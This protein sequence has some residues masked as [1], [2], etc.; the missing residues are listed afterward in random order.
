M[1]GCRAVLFLVS[2]ILSVGYAAVCPAS[3]GIIPVAKFQTSALHGGIPEGWSLEKKTG[4]PVIS[5]EKDNDAFYVHLVSGGNSSFGLRK[6]ARVDVKRYP[7]LSWRWKATKLPKG[8]DVRKSSTDDQ[9]LQIYV[10]F[11]ESGLLGMNTPVI[12]YIWD[13]D[14]PKGWTG[15][16]PQT[17]GDKLRYIVLRNKTDNVGQWYTERRNIYQ[18]YKR[19]FADVN[20]GEP[21]STTTGLQIYINSQ[22]TK[23]PA[24]GMVGEIYFS[25]EPSD[26]AAAEAGQEVA[27][28]RV[29]RISAVKP[30]TISKKRS[31]KIS[32]T[33]ACINVSIEFETD[34]IMIEESYREKLK[35]V[36]DY[37]GKNGGIQL[38]VVG[39]TDNVGKEEYNIALSQRRAENVRDYLVE[40]F[41][42]NP[43]SLNAQGVGPSYPVADNDTPEGR[44]RNRNVIIS[45]CPEE[46]F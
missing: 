15:R 3:P 6:E 42:V 27:S 4:R 10:A 11:K 7:I 21:Q 20:G 40:Q 28:K 31:G 33:P 13:N 36:A 24:E 44:R 22:R 1:K 46:Y 14:A 19:L 37:L 12:G 39:H 18:D 43:Q 29:A 38:R 23:S 16:S 26:I 2:L 41:G 30:P 5:M 8:G 45:D 9:A 35:T 25:N 17:G 32:A 34:S